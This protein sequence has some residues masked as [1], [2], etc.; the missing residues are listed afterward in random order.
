MSS[1][2]RIVVSQTYRLAWVGRPFSF[3]RCCGQGCHPL[4]QAA[5]GPTQTWSQT[6]PV[7]RCVSAPAGHALAWVWEVFGGG[8]VVR[9]LISSHTP[10]PEDFPSARPL[11]VHFPPVPAFTME[12]FTCI[13]LSI[14]INLC[15]TGA[16]AF[17]KCKMVNFYTPMLNVFVN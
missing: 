3:N 15:M 10:H 1:N 9:A 17:I 8:C 4:G 6:P 13:K 7:M 14:C 12:Y 5:R 16:V 2:H 11:H